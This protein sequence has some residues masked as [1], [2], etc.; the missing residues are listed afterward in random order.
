MGLLE[1]PDRFVGRWEIDSDHS[2]L[3]FGVRH[4]MVSRVRG[5]FTRCRGWFQV[6]ESWKVTGDI[7]I[8]AAS[9]TTGNQERDEHLRTNDFLDVRRY[10][11]VLFVPS[12]L[13]MV[14][15]EKGRLEGDL[16]IKGRTHPITL[17]LEPL[18][19]LDRDAKDHRRMSFAVTGQINRKDFDVLWNR[20]LESGGVLVGDEV[21]IDL[22]VTATS[23]HPRANS[24]ES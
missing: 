13:L 1:E 2:S 5:S 9:I 12:D 4:M 7:R 16:T 17:D 11:E 23:S 15:P 20:A 14:S 3:G 24:S 21:N 18:G 10:P 22:Q 19:Y 8:E 6:G